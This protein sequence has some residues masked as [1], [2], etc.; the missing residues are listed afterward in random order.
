MKEEWISLSVVFS[1]TPVIIKY[2]VEL[3]VLTIK[4]AFTRKNIGDCYGTLYIWVGRIHTW[5]LFHFYSYFAL[6]YTGI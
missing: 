6:V 4:S 2:T 1:V 3:K 5:P